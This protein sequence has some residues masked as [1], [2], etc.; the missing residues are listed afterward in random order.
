MGPL[1]LHNVKRSRPLDGLGSSIDK[2]IADPCAR[3][4]AARCVLTLPSIAEEPDQIRE[5]F[6]LIPGEDSRVQTGTL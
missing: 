1:L 6:A 2:I 4:G 5:M 3:S